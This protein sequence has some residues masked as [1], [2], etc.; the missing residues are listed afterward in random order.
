[1]A[2][3]GLLALIFTEMME[4]KAGY[5]ALLGGLVYLIPSGLFAA[6]FFRKSGA[7]AGKQIVFNFYWGEIVKIFISALL[8]IVIF[9]WI[10]VSVGVFFVTY[11]AAQLTFWFSPLLVS[12]ER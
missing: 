11:L 5:S 3:V 10:A 6:I 8:F 4:P 7:N 2:F 1:M 12:R 9:K